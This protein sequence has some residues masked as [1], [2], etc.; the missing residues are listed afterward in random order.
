MQ[1]YLAYWTT[2]VVWLGDELFMKCLSLSVSAICDCS[3]VLF[4]KITAVMLK[5]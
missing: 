3:S 2:L 1:S 4:I 5:K